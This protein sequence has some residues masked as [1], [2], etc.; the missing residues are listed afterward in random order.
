MDDLSNKKE[1]ATQK[2]FESYSNI[3]TMH[4][5]KFIISSTTSINY[6]IMAKTFLFELLNWNK[7]RK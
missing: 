7:T 5:F 4:L 1:M 3:L 6:N 2:C